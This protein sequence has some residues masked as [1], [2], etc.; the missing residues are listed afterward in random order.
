MKNYVINI[1]GQLGIRNIESLVREASNALTA[2]TQDEEFEVTFG[3]TEVRG[4]FATGLAA[5]TA[6]AQYI[7]QSPQFRYGYFLC[8]KNSD[9]HDYMTRMRLYRRLGM[10]VDYPFVE[11][12]PSGRFQELVEIADIGAVNKTSNA[13]A[14]IVRTQNRA[15]P[16]QSI[17]SVCSTLS[18]LID[19]VF[20]HAQSPINAI[21]CA[22]TYPLQRSIELAIVD[23]GRGFRRSLDDNP[24]YQGS[25]ATASEA[26]GL[27]MQR[28][29]TCSPERNTGEGLYFTRELVKLNRGDM[30]ICS[31]DG[32]CRVRNGI[33]TAEQM[34]YNGLAV[35]WPGT[36]AAVRLFFDRPMDMKP[37]YDREA[38]PDNDF[39]LLD[40]EDIPF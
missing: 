4:I 15:I 3:L 31:E 24:Q 28:R 32:L 23:C 22:Q 14:E 8:P 20:H 5:L 30:I 1:E 34:C 21:V 39:V 37:I 13:L 19:N 7:R 17:N 18:E 38:P 36:I 33:E 40:E 25:Y 26:I 6:V 35:K 27:A 2:C 12:D 9:V 10:N 29:V 11:H 16:V